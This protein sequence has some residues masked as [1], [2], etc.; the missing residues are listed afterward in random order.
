MRF[1][2]FWVRG[3]DRS[4]Q[5]LDLKEQ[6][7]RV[8]TGTNIVYLVPQASNR[9]VNAAMNPLH[10]NPWDGVTD[11]WT[12]MDGL[13][14]RR[15]DGRIDFSRFLRQITIVLVR[16]FKHTPLIYQRDDAFFKNK[17]RIVKPES[18]KFI[19]TSLS[20]LLYTLTTTNPW[21]SEMQH[22]V[23]TVPSHRL[24]I[25]FIESFVHSIFFFLF[26]FHL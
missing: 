1:G 9:R 16:F 3:K 19:P 26:F 10:E 4:T 24:C 2:Q 11:L 7:L 23:P 14:D 18:K 20:L 25:L 8:K 21:M 6:I 22:A 13:T 15:I 5:I 12:P 17:G